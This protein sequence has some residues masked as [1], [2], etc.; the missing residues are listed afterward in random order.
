MGNSANNTLTGNNG[1][2]TLIGREGNDVLL[3]G[4]GKDSLS[5][6]LGNDSLSGGAGKDVLDGGAG[7]DTLSGGADLDTFAFH[8][9]G[10]DK[11][12]GYEHGEKFDLSTLHVSW[13]EVHITASSIVVDLAGVDDLTIMLNTSGIGR[14]DFIFA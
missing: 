2:D 5:G 10:T 7:N 1:E 13:A 11:I 3:G 8:D 14:N 6:G 4:N 12:I 9:A